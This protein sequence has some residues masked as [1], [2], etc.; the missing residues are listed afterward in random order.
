MQGFDSMSRKQHQQLNPRHA[1]VRQLAAS[2]TLQ[3]RRMVLTGR[4][5]R[6]A[7]GVCKSPFVAPERWYEPQEDSA[8]E[9]RIVVQE[10]GAGYRHAVT[11]E[12]I[13]Q[14]LEQAPGELVRPLQVVQLSN[15]TRKKKLFSCYGMQWGNAV[16]LYPMPANLV[17]D[18][19]RPPLPRERHEA[20]MYG[21][22][23]EQ[24][25][26][27]AWRLIWTEQAIR[28]YYLNNIL[29]HELGHLHDRRNRRHADRE[30][31]AEWF[32][33][34]YGYQPSRPA[35]PPGKPVRRRHHGK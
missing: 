35:A 21:G 2:R 1:P 15:L 13:R 4:R 5:A 10:P 34:R 30:R 23:W 25:G 16:Y 8:G 31:F 22:R 32:A 6:L 33:V 7:D 19:R 27:G 18:L 29:F 20:A 17:E 28:D 26:D 24:D 3:S 11:P 14:R 9:Y 12:E